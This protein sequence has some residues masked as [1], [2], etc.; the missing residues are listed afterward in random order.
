MN[1]NGVGA[2]TL[3]YLRGETDMVQE[4]ERIAQVKKQFQGSSLAFWLSGAQKRRMERFWKVASLL[5]ENSR[6]SLTEMSRKLKVSVSTLFD[7]LKDLEKFFH[8]TIVLKENEWDAPTR[9][10]I[11][12]EFAYQVT[13]DTGQEDGKQ[14]TFNSK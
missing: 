6:M 13:I 3:A 4:Q 1:G 7:T 5:Q 8:F 2:R 10:S 9:D 11:P 12:V 14:T